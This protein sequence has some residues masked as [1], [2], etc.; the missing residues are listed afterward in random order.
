LASSALAEAGT[1][2]GQPAWTEAAEEAM[3]F[4]LDDM[5]IGGR[6]MRSYR[7]GVIKHLAFAEDYAFVLE[8]CLALFEA[9]GQRSWLNEARWAADESLRL[10]LDSDTGGFFTTGE[11]AERL[12]TRAKDMIDNAIPAANSVF[13]M[14]LQRLALFTGERSYEDHAMRIMDQLAGSMEQAPL[15][16]GHLLGAVDLYT[17]EALEVVIIGDPR[18]P[19]TQ[20]LLEV[21][22]ETYLPNKVLLVS[23]AADPSVPLLRDRTRMDGV[24]TAYVCRSMVCKQ[25]VTSPDALREQLGV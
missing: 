12:V 17:S 1:I 10:F 8:A 16:F 7:I 18:A 13:A 14:E 24:A 19:D 22:R 6:L 21:V 2:L 23:A 11:D 25:P 4:I 15:G 20:A 5:R 3:G 9:T